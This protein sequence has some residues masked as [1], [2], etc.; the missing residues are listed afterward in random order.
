MLSTQIFF[1]LQMEIQSA[2]TAFRDITYGDDHFNDLLMHLQDGFPEEAYHL[3]LLIGECSKQK[4][5]AF[6]Q[7]A[8]SSGREVVEAEANSIIT[9]NEA[10]CRKNL[11]D[12]FERF[13]PD[14]QLLHLKNGSRLSGVYTGHT[15][16]RVRYATPQ[17][18][19]FLQKLQEAGGLFVIDIDSE[20]GADNTILRA[21]QSIVNF[22]PPQ[23]GLKK[24]LWNLKQISVQ[25]SHIDN[26]RPE[27][28]AG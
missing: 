24:L 1:D 3:C 21:A 23:S 28:Y 27:Q 2:Q 7:I 25:G 18:R 9:Q 15:L 6:Q 8:E 4:R 13:S 26:K 16:S 14:E 11:N 20:A 5:K 19:Y 17:E 22:P 12:I 10:Q